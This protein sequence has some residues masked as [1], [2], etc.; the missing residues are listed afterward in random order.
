M[1]TQGP[2][3]TMIDRLATTLSTASLS[4]LRLRFA[5][6]FYSFVV[7]GADSDSEHVFSKTHGPTA[8]TTTVTTA[9]DD[10]RKTLQLVL[11]GHTVSDK[12]V[13]I[14]HIGWNGMDEKTVTR[15]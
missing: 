14:A 11:R 15:G 5:T 6:V 12:A 1:E 8:T 7:S 10:C 3:S 9:T 4:R 13:D 2:T